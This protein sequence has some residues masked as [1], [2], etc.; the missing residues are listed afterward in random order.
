MLA[1]IAVRS[2]NVTRP[3]V[4]Q[5]A[6]KNVVYAMIARNVARGEC[7]IFFPRIDVLKSGRKSSHLLEIPWSAGVAGW[8]WRFCGGSLDVWG[9]SVS[10]VCSGLS[11]LLMFALV[12]R[13]HGETAAWG[14]SAVLAFSPVSIIYGQMFMLEASLVLL[15]L[16]ALWTTER[17]LQ[18]ARFWSLLSSWGCATLLFTGKVYFL[19]MAWV[20]AKSVWQQRLLPEKRVSCRLYLIHLGVAAYMCLWWVGIVLLI[21]HDPTS[22]PHIFFSLADSTRTHVDSHTILLSGSFYLRLISDL[23]LRVLTPV[24]VVL[25]IVALTQREWRRHTRWLA[26]SA[27]WVLIMPRKFYEM[28]YYHMLTLP[29]LCVMAGLGWKAIVARY[30]PGAWVGGTVLIIGLGLSLRLAY[31]PAFT[32]PE[33][34]RYVVAAA[35]AVAEHVPCD[36]PIATL[37]GSTLDLLYYCDRP[38]WALVAR[39]D[40]ATQL[41]E[42]RTAGAKHLIVTGLTE[43]STHPHSQAAFAQLPVVVDHPGYRLYRLSSDAD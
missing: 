42:V 17:Y 36:E 31:V 19:V 16:L 15:M 23:V 25:A 26:V 41:A 40:L 38:G 21:A 35:E 37:H 5:F 43:L 13:W 32:V 11:V 28:N 14:A 33:E 10:I 29:V 39:D 12:R 4:G 22:S 3:L 1:A 7:S 30:R 6:T 8:G 18:H 20:L 2:W 34:D 9:R 27:L 24:G